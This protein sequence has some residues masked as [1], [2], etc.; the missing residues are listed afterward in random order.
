MSYASILAA[1]RQ[2]DMNISLIGWSHLGSPIV[3]NIR[4]PCLIF[5]CVKIICMY[6]TL[7]RNTYHCAHCS[8]QFGKG[9][10]KLQNEKSSWKNIWKKKTLAWDE[11]REQRR[12][13]METFG[14]YKF[15]EPMGQRW[16]SQQKLDH[17]EYFWRRKILAMET[18]WQFVSSSGP[19]KKDDI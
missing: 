18:K 8:S 1:Q 4:Q 13:S 10:Y 17:E 5:G 12:K 14:N 3:K 7:I 11:D 6:C 15:W 2:K 9:K 16:F 19:I